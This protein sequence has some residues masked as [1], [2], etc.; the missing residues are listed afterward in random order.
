MTDGSAT[1]SERDYH[2]MRARSELDAAYRAG[3]FKVAAAHLKLCSLHMERARNFQAPRP[4]AVELEWIEKLAPMHEQVPR[5]VSGDA[6]RT[7]SSTQTQPLC[8]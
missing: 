7:V 6:A 1:G 4:H 5:I 3:S 8:G 2:V